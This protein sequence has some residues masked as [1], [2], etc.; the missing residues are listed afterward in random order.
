MASIVLGSTTVI[1]ESSGTVTLPTGT[2]NGIIGN[3]ATVPSNIASDSGSYLSPAFKPR[4]MSSW[5]TVTTDDQTYTGT[6][7]LSPAPIWGVCQYA[8]T[9]YTDAVHEGGWPN[10][11]YPAGSTT[12]NDDASLFNFDGNGWLVQIDDDVTYK[13][14]YTSY[15]DTGRENLLSSGYSFRVLLF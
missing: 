3:T 2:F 7:S 15:T 10:V 12:H 5:Q 11:S 14:F 6:H 1:T 8:I 4:Y 13:S 9:G